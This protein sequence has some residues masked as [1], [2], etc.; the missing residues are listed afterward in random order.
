[1]EQTLCPVTVAVPGLVLASSGKRPV[2]KCLSRVQC[3]VHS[4]KFIWDRIAPSNLRSLPTP[5]MKALHPRLTPQ[6]LSG[7]AMKSS[8]WQRS[9]C[10][11][12]HME[13]ERHTKSND[14]FGAVGSRH[15]QWSRARLVCSEELL[16]APK[17]LRNLVELRITPLWTQFA[18]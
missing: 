14:T 17:N 11:S 8:T 18:T 15:S 10:Y 5:S 6:M 9:L 1:M 7:R 4:I 2:G 13:L 12:R 16:A 3:R